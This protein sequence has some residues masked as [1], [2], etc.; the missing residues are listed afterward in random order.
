MTSDRSELSPEPSYREPR[1]LARLNR[2]TLRTRWI[3]AGPLALLM[4]ILSMASLPH[5]WP[6]GEGGV[7]HLVMPVVLFPLIWAVLVVLPLLP[8]RPGK[9]LVVYSVTIVVELALLVA[10][11]VA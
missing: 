3:S 11:L 10:G 5:I 9:F 6:P 2:N 1:F 4:A 8:E 7:D